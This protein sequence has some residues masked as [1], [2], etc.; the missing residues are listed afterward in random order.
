MNLKVKP[1][2]IMQLE[3]DFKKTVRYFSSNK[4]IIDVTKIIDGKLII[5][6]EKFETIFSN[7]LPNLYSIFAYEN[8]I[9]VLKY[10]GETKKS[11]S[12]T[13][14]RNHLIKKHDKTG[15]KLAKVN[16]LLAQNIKIG[17]KSI[18][19]NHE[20]LRLYFEEK[21]INSFKELP[22]NNFKI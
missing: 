19:L 7:G 13:R 2:L 3:L 21:L 6:Q 5:D 17:I 8:N 4:N 9:W 14:L 1:E 15:S 11:I 22:W 18:K 12:R 20:E 10:I 16:E